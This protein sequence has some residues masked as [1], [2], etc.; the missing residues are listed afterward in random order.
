MTRSPAW[1]RA[2]PRTSGRWWKSWTTSGSRRASR[3]TITA[4]A[5]V[6][7]AASA[8][9]STSARKARRVC[10]SRAA[11]IAAS[12]AAASARA[13]LSGYSAR[14]ARASARCTSGR[15]GASATASSAWA[16]AP[17]VS[18]AASARE[19][20]RASA[21]ASA[22]RFSIPSSRRARSSASAAA[23]ARAGSPSRSAPRRSAQRSMSSACVIETGTMRRAPVLR[24]RSAASR[25]RVPRLRAA[26]GGATLGMTG[27]GRSGRLFIPGRLG[28]TRRP[29]RGR[30]RSPSLHRWRGFATLGV[31]GLMRS[32]RRRGRVARRLP[33]CRGLLGDLLALDDES[34]R[35]D[36]RGDGGGDGER[37]ERDEEGVRSAVGHRERDAS[38][39][40]PGLRRRE[41]DA[42][43]RC[44]RT[45]PRDHG[46]PPRP[47]RLPVGPR[48][49]TSEPA[50]L[51]AR[52]DVRGARGHRRGRRARPTVRSSATF[53]SRSSSRPSSPRRRGSSTS[54][55]SPT[56]SRASSSR[57]TR[58]SSATSERRRTRTQVLRQWAA[59][60]KKEKRAKG[61]GKSVLEGV[62]REMPAL[63]RAERLTEKASRI[64]FDWPDAAGAREKVTE[65]LGELDEAIASG[66]RAADGGRARG[67]PLRRRESVPEARDTRRRRRSA[68]SS[69]FVSRFEHIEDELA[70][71]GV[72]HGSATLE[73][74]DALWNEAKVLEGKAKSAAT[75]T[76]AA[77]PQGSGKE[78]GQFCG[79]PP[80]E[81]DFHENDTLCCDPASQSKPSDFHV[82][83]PARRLIHPQ[84]RVKCPSRIPASSAGG[85]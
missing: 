52:G 32:G 20:A 30:G 18:P 10:G 77:P 24:L 59:L 12:R 34:R 64:G 76:V 67:R 45:S 78:R 1:T 70:R 3:R 62:P 29:G 31:T 36:L 81:C 66:D 82:V 41:H 35:R 54:P 61:R 27:P 46:A 7:A 37:E 50:A 38:T 63:A 13:G 16:T 60:K 8:A 71:R 14:R 43:D 25:R 5:A 15:S 49:D 80:R 75:L 2:V 40:A 56:R 19:A 85:G 9:A 83:E 57:A 79:Q 17:A 21:T 48:A 6:T 28:R 51:R 47:R 23:S 55:T 44:D 74:M 33:R 84:G 26:F 58:T 42:R 22:G 39:P 72:P 53:S 4:A 65:E 11:A 69:R 68:D 73:E